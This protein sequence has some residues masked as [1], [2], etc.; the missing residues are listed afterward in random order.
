MSAVVQ[1][2]ER[3]M[4][5]SCPTMKLPDCTFSLSPDLHPLPYSISAGAIDTFRSEYHE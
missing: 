4:G 5:I 1:L 3:W 2:V